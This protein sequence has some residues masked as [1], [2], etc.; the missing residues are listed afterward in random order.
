MEKRLPLKDNNA[1]Y[2]AVKG[3][4]DSKLRKRTRKRGLYKLVK[5]IR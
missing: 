4:R 2:A 5:T 1:F 3:I